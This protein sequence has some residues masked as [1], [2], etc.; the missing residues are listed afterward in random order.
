MASVAGIVKMA[1]RIKIPEKLAF[2]FKPARYKVAWG[3]RG[4]SKSWSYALALLFLAINGRERILCT[5]EYQNSIQESVH[6]L[7]CDQIERLGWS[8]LFTITQQSIR[9]VN[10]SEFIFAGIKTDPAKIKSTEGVTRCWVEEAEKVSA[11]SWEKLIPTIRAPGSEIWVSFNPDL[12]TDPTY[13]RFVVN[14]PPDAKIV[15]M[16]WRDNPWFP[17]ILR[18]E[19]DYLASVDSDAYEHVWN[20]ACREHSEAQ[21][22]KGKYLIRD[23]T[24]NHT[25]QGPY[26]GADWGFANDPTV[27]VKCWLHRDDLYIE[28]EAYGIGID[29]D[30]TPELFDRVSGAREHVIRADSARPETISYMRQNGYPKIEAVRK[31]G[32][33]VEDGIARLRSFNQIVIH[34]SCKHAA[35]EARLWSYKVDRLTK[36]ILPVVIDKHNHIWDAVRYSLAPIIQENPFGPLDFGGAGGR[37]D[38]FSPPNSGY[39]SLL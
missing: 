31:W 4:G 26:Y 23:F 5:R 36:D 10:G 30:R 14:P 20:G 21:I 2:L 33:S 37:D 28:A 13:Q 16:N 7:L 39:A 18:K 29:I 22:L 1:E 34:P 35:E 38:C 12:S 9:A 32:G 25:W 3:G 11:E 15:Q 27:L 17:D 24:V 19:K 6:R 8:H